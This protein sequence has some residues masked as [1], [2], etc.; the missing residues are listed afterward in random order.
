MWRETEALSVPVAMDFSP[1]LLVKTARPTPDVSAGERWGVEWKEKEFRERARDVGER[2]GEEETREAACCSWSSNSLL[3][4][5]GAFRTDGAELKEPT[6]QAGERFSFLSPC[7]PLII[8]SLTKAVEEL[9]QEWVC[10][11]LK[12]SFQS[13]PPRIMV[14]LLGVWFQRDLFPKKNCSWSEVNV[15]NLF[16]EFPSF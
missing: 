14:M 9:K 15:R 12:F 13:E 11:L 5:P 8:F 1:K 6:A 16:G 4:S 3:R 10:L 7:A 2:E